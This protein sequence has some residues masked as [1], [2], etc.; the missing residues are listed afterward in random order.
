M[1]DAD[2]LI[3]IVD[4]SEIV[5]AAAQNA[6]EEEG[7]SVQALKEPVSF[8]IDEDAPPSLVLLDINMPQVYGDD[9]A[10]FLKE[11]WDVK[12]PIYLFSDLPEPELERR[13]R[14]A[15]ADG[16]ICKSWGLKALV[17]KVREIVASQ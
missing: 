10:Q 2:K 6:L 13:C 12:A 9:V 5:L 16:Y 15:G 17:E 1:A 3:I 7:F 11:E 4:D 14:H 8:S